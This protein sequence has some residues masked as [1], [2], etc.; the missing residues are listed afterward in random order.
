MCGA[1]CKTFN[2]LKG[3]WPRCIEASLSNYFDTVPNTLKGEA[4]RELHTFSRRGYVDGL[5]LL[6]V[7]YSFQ[8]SAKPRGAST[9]HNLL[10]EYLYWALPKKRALPVTHQING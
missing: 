5:L 4:L 1:P 3:P 8:L 9:Y 10:L 2:R 6:P 7:S